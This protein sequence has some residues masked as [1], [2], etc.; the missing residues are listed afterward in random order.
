MLVCGTNVMLR[1]YLSQGIDCL[2]ICWI[3]IKEKYTRGELTGPG[4]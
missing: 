4:L 3:D 2:Y 1:A